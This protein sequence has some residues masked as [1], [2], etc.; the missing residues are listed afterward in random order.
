MRDE[1][2]ISHRTTDSGIADMI[3]D[4]LVN[5]GIP[6]DKIF[7]S[8]LPGNDVG[9]RIAPEVKAHLQ[10][11][12]INIL[13]LSRDYYAS[14]YCLNEAGIAWYLEDALAIPFG[15]PEIDHTNMYGFL[16][17][18]YKLRR[19]DNEDDIAYLYD[20]AQQHL[21][22]NSVSHSTITRET[23][24][25]KDRYAKYLSERP[26]AP[27]TVD[28]DE[29]DGIDYDD[30]VWED[31][32]HQVKNGDGKI[33]KEGIFADGELIDGIEYNVI[34]QVWKGKE[35]HKEA[36]PLNKLE[37][38]SW[39]HSECGQYDDFLMWMLNNRE[40]INAQ[41][42]FFYVVDKKVKPEGKLIKTTFTNFRTLESVL[43]E[44]DPDELDYIKTGV[45]KYQETDYA[46]IEID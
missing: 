3:K 45:S 4:F 28:S 20:E 8:S 29:A 11:S 35:D 19:V 42:P 41:L 14:A 46:D 39:P 30:E 34:L 2:F 23:R 7:C 33:V 38:K 18:D 26:T 5:T 40:I 22:T 43:S 37:E 9:E 17:A 27:E 32:Y 25:L 31:G 44:N 6:N 36:V 12:A 1:I 24:K 16:N 10:K 15:L 21:S 13:L